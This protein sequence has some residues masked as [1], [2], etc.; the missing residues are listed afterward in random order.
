MKINTLDFI[1]KRNLNN[2]NNN[3]GKDKIFYDIFCGT[4]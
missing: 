4:S 2:N 1:I 3:I